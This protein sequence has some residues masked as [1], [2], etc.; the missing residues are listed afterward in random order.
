[1]TVNIRPFN[2]TPT[3]ATATV[4]QPNSASGEVAGSVTATDADGDLQI[5]RHV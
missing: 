3:G 4:G 1:M 5:Y 2:T